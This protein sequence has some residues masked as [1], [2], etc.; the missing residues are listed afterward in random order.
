MGAGDW[1]RVRAF[2]G[3]AVLTA[4][5]PGG[6]PSAQAPAGRVFGSDAGMI[7]NTIKAEKTGDFEAVV[8]K[9][10]EALQKSDKLERRQ[11]AASWRVFKAVEQGANSTAVYVFWLDPPVKG[12]DYT[13]SKILA[14]A[15]PGEVQELYKKFSDAYAGGQNVVNLQLVSRMGE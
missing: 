5:I 7:L 11:Q 2:A 9:L 15:F 8:A 12:A 6:D 14:E 1:L 3:D 13:V 10:K 4:G